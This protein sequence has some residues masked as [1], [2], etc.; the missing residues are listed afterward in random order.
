MAAARGADPQEPHHQGARLEDQP[1][2]GGTGRAFHLPHLGSGQSR[3]V[4]DLSAPAAWMLL[5]QLFLPMSPLQLYA[6]VPL[7]K[8]LPCPLP[9]PCPTAAV[10]ASRQRQPAFSRVE[11]AQGEAVGAV[12]DCADS[13]FMRSGQPCF[14]FLYAPAVSERATTA[15]Q[16][17]KGKG[18]ACQCKFVRCC[19]ARRAAEGCGLSLPA[20]SPPTCAACLP[21]RLQGDPAIEAVVL[22]V[23]QRN[24]PPIP[25]E[26]VLG[27]SN[28][29]A[30]DNWLLQHPETVSSRDGS[31]GRL[32]CICIAERG[33]S[34]GGQAGLQVMCCD[35]CLLCCLL[36]CRCVACLQA[37]AAVIFSTEPS[38]S[39]A[40]TAALPAMP[41]PGDI[42]AGLPGNATT[43]ILAYPTSA[44]D[45]ASA[46][47]G[48]SPFGFGGAFN[49]RG[50]RQLG[51]SIQSNSSVKWFKGRY[52]NPNTYIQVGAVCCTGVP[53]SWRWECVVGAAMQAS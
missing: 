36:P 33:K 22:G 9:M 10:S 11:V 23:R 44:A 1:A 27:L 32:V 5:P 26:H 41:A 48:G 38:R 40:A 3:W 49:S 30:V 52:Q 8:R 19:L 39:G 42:T 34:A 37:L 14:T 2:R 29:S 35:V 47:A 50:P 43:P 31:H 45:P 53:A 24:D 6:T 20:L 18:A 12:P 16:L 46:A 28:A 17:E 13:L 7:G 25:P 51:F 21:W 15:S 4:A